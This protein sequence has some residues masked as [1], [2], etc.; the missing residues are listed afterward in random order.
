METGKRKAF[1]VDECYLLWGDACGY[2]WGSAAQ[3]VQIPI[4][5]QRER[6]TY[7]GALDILSGQLTLQPLL[8]GDGENCVL[9]LQTLQQQHPNC[10]LVIFW[11][12]AS[13]HRFGLVRQYLRQLNEGVPESEW[14]ITCC[15]LAPHAPDQNPVEDVWLQGKQQVRKNHHLCQGFV[16]VKELFVKAVTQQAFHFPKLVQYRRSHLI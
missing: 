11:D 12:G 7:Y 5:N 8:A 13:Y 15:L 10:K 2:V 9:F 6:Q 16:D 1:F 3:R 4:R 14:L